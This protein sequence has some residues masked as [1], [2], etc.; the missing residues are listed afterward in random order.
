MS[1]AQKWVVLLGLLGLGTLSLLL[2][3]DVNDPIKMSIACAPRPF[4][5]RVQQ[6]Y[7]G[8][9]TAYCECVRE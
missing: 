6:G 9:S 5:C 8:W 7:N 4:V 2:F 3:T 1:S